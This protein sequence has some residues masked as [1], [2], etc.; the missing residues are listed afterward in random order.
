MSDA[1][2]VNPSSVRRQPAV[3]MLFNFAFAIF[4]SAFLLF[5]IQPLIGKF[6]LPWFGGSPSV[7]TTCML[8][9]QAALFCGYAYAH[10][11]NRW[12][13]PTRQAIIH[14]ALLV[15]AL[16]LLHVAPDSSLKP[17]GADSPVSRILLLLAK[18]VGLPYFALSATGPLLQA[19]FS[20]VY[21]KRSPYRLY[22][23]SNTG[24]LLALVS[25][26]FVF[27]PA[28]A[29]QTQAR[30]WS[31]SFAVFV[32]VCALVALSVTRLASDRD[33]PVSAASAQESERERLTWPRRLRWVGLAACASLML[34]AGT[35]HICTDVA[36]IPFLWVVPLAL[37]LLSF[38][39]TF[40]HGSWY[41]P[42]AYASATLALVLAVG[43]LD[44]L[45]DL[46]GELHLRIGFGAS[47]ALYFSALFSICMT[48]HGELARSRP[49]PAHL[50]EFYLLISAGGALGGC[51]VSLLAPLLFSSFLE[52][53]L[54]LCASLLL[55][56][57]VLYQGVA[58]RSRTVKW[59]LAGVA[60]T[61]VGAIALSQ[62]DTGDDTLLEA[63]RNFYGVVAV[64]DV[65]P[66]EPAHHLSLTH[67]IVVHGRQFVAPEKRSQPI[68]YYSEAAG[69]GR[70]IRLL[71]SRPELR[72][73]AVGLGVG[74]LAAYA[75]A[76]DSIRFYEINPNVE[77]L[78]KRYF[79]FLHDSR[80]QIETLIGDARLSLEREAARN[81]DL[82]VLDAFSGD[83]VPAH[84]VT[85]EAFAVYLRHLR[86]DGILAVNIT[87]RQLDLA[88]VILGVAAHY[89]LKPVRVYTEGDEER[90]LYRADWMLLARSEELHDAIAPAPPPAEAVVRAPRMWTDHY[91]DLFGIL[92]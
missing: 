58:P 8:F 83:A 40:D 74:T 4:L 80:G 3:W 61:L 86:P 2:L 26:P 18:T 31:W 84:L 9:F 66:G 1:L 55:S 25:Y 44:P 38:I 10:L 56:F 36:V 52:W 12:L 22:A 35:N 19:W 89:G 53:T 23:L 78:A 32:L 42:R 76:H 47:L 69:V 15:L 29:A 90:L 30:L 49:A 81:F 34:L 28:F 72:I 82:L 16:C 37:Y 77:R 68:A 54:G 57:S 64:Y 24:S 62:A 14:G 21:P 79:S 20:R 17:V 75:R 50:T 67:G 60:T 39:V 7:W 45:Q 48:C 65:D 6:I 73:G 85:R 59:G 5:Q 51:F 11:L 46:L 70:A 41:R 92:R 33:E 27:E 43:C 63:A 88:P 71:Q 91:S 13:V 87:N